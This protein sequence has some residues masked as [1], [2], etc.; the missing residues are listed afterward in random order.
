M[1]LPKLSIFNSEHSI[2]ADTALSLDTLKEVRIGIY[3]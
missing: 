1:F 3:C 2:A